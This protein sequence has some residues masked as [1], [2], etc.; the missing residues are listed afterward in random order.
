VD[1]P[2]VLEPGRVD[3]AGYDPPGLSIPFGLAVCEVEVDP[4]TGVVKLQ[5]LVFGHD[6][7]TQFNPRI[8][9]G[10]VLGGAMQSVGATL[11]EEIVCDEGA[12]PL[13]WSLHDYCLPFAGYLVAFDAV[14]TETQSPF[15][16]NGAKGVGESGTIP[17]P[18]AI[19]NAVHDAFG[20]G[21]GLCVL[22]LTPERVFQYLREGERL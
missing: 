11:S 13:A 18:A 16:L 21:R 5:R 12:Q 20:G 4:A 8:V 1:H 19:A 17:M 14:H 10:Q 15:S 22:P 7:G 3:H 6:C 2:K 9:E